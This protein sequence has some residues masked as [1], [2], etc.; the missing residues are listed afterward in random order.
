MLQSTIRRAIAGGELSTE[1]LCEIFAESEA[2]ADLDANLSRVTELIEAQRGLLPSVLSAALRSDHRLLELSTDEL[3]ALMPLWIDAAQKAS[4]ADARGFAWLF[5]MLLERGNLPSVTAIVD[6]LR[7][8]FMTAPRDVSQVALEHL[9]ASGRPH[10]DD[11]PVLE[12]LDLH[13]ATGAVVGGVSSALGIWL[14]GEESR[15]RTLVS[16]ASGGTLRHRLRAAR[17]LCHVAQCGDVLAQERIDEAVGLARRLLADPEERVWREAARALAH[18]TPYAPLEELWEPDAWEREE[19]LSR[20]AA[21]V[22]AFLSIDREW[23]AALVDELTAPNASAGPRTPA[24]RQLWV[25]LAHAYEDLAQ[26]AGDAADRV[27]AAI[28]EASFVPAVTALAHALARLRLADKTNAGAAGLAHRID[29]AFGASEK[30]TSVQWEHALAGREALMVARGKQ[31]STSLRYAVCSLVRRSLAGEPASQI[32]ASL[33]GLISTIGQRLEELD[34]PIFSEEAPVLG[35]RLRGLEDLLDVLFREDLLTALLTAPSPDASSDTHVSKRQLGR[36]KATLRSLIHRHAGDDSRPRAW[37]QRALQSAA[38]IATAVPDS[39]VGRPANP[40]TIGFYQL[41]GL[42]EFLRGWVHDTTPGTPASQGLS[43]VLHALLR[44]SLPGSGDALLACLL[45]A[46]TVGALERLALVVTRSEEPPLMMQLVDNLRVLAGADDLPGNRLSELLTAADGVFTQILEH[47]SFTSSQARSTVVELRRHIRSAT[48]HERLISFMTPVRRTL[49]DASEPLLV[50]LARDIAGLHR[51]ANEWAEPARIVALRS[52]GDAGDDLA[53]HAEQVVSGAALASAS[54]E[55]ELVVAAEDVGDA[56]RQGAGAVVNNRLARTDALAASADGLTKMS[57]LVANGLRGCLG[58]L[59]A[60]ILRTWSEL[61]TERRHRSLDEPDHPLL[62]DR[63]RIERLLG[64]GGMAF[65]YLARDP[66]LD[67]N[68]TL[69][70]MKPAICR[71]PALRTLFTEE[72][73][74]IA[75]LPPHAHV[76][77]AYEFLDSALAPCLVMEYVDGEALFD[78]I[79]DDGMPLARGLDIAVAAAQGLHHVHRHKMVHLDIKSENV[80]VSQDGTPKLIDFGLAQRGNQERESSGMILGTPCYMSPEQ[81][82]GRPLDTASDVYSFGVLLYELFTGDV[83]FDDADPQEILRMHVTEAPEPMS[84][85]RPGLPD[86]L[87]LLVSDTLEKSPENRPWM[88]EVASRLSR[89]QAALR[90]SEAD[91]SNLARREVAVLCA[92][93]VGLDPEH[94]P[95]EDV[96]QMLETFLTASNEIVTGLKGRVDATVGVRVYAVFD[97]ASAVDNAVRAASMLRAR[98]RRLAPGDLDVHAGIAN[99]SALVG[100]VRG[101]PTDATVLGAPLEI[102]TRLADEALQSA[103]IIIDEP[104]HGMLRGQVE[105]Q[106]HNKISGIGRTYV[107]IPP[108][109]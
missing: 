56:V 3:A 64:E 88:V 57:A 58:D 52:I 31:P 32:E 43:T 26:E 8:L 79:P 15:W 70:V 87:V 60:S 95:S 19:H 69:K 35:G 33:G 96:A 9:L 90:P 80:M 5:G 45:R 25:A 101:D 46:P 53:G 36:Q 55:A 39:P 42:P 82:Q 28:L 103:S 49:E 71:Q 99:G 97:Y 84:L 4:P 2:E 23:G 91:Q 108:D 30:P 12:R 48:G 93:L 98:I 72:G 102:A 78:V 100:R 13:L 50:A 74:A 44:Q 37:R 59:L 10:T 34:A 41:T 76:V 21:G 73:K 92:G 7:R 94:R 17:L 16:D 29:H 14:V 67:R 75:A 106:K 51:I 61:V 20:L 62:V 38:L 105:T 77:Q 81:A 89:I 68:V 104:S 107:V 22:G 65:T 18:L 85:R 54:F 24:Q 11:G 40:R 1:A 27:A 83:P 66:D 86:G 63:F 109:R 6:E 47:T